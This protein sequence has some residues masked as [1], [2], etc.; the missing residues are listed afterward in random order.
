MKKPT[1]I[2][3]VLDRSETDTHLLEKASQLARRFGASLE[4]FVCDA[5]RAYALK[6][7]YDPHHVDEARRACIAE[8]NDYLAR[9]IHAAELHDVRV[10]TDAACESP[11]YEGIVRKTLQSR[12]DLVMKNASG[13]DSPEAFDPNDWQLMRKCPATLLMTRGRTWYPQPR[14]AAAVDVSAAESVGLAGSILE[15]AEC[16]RRANGAELDIL[17]AERGSVGRETGE[18][19]AAALRKLA[20]QSQIAQDHVHILDGDPERALPEFAREH[21][22]DVLVLGALTDHRGTVPLVGTLTAKLMEAI[23]C[24]FVLVKPGLTQPVAALR[25]DAP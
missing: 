2:L 10:S 21:D 9:L 12:P 17:Y 19:R 8:A 1:Q 16:L 24:D 18:A 5:E 6:R 22:Y 15:N 23:D 7:E 4:L 11:L 20:C 13:V 14:F 3:A 25:G